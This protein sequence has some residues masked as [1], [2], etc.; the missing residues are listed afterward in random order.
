[1]TVDC[2]ICH[3]QGVAVKDN[4][5]SPQREPEMDT[6][7]MCG[8]EGKIEEHPTSKITIK[9]YWNVTADAV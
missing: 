6:C 8:G 7:W 2:P 4:G 9:K 5:V 1:M 3:G